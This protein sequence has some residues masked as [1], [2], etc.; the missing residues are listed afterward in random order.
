MGRGDIK[1]NGPLSLVS[2]TWASRITNLIHLFA[3]LVDIESDSGVNPGICEICLFTDDC[4][5]MLTLN[6]LEHLDMSS[7]RLATACM[8]LIYCFMFNSK[9]L[10]SWK[11][12]QLKHS[13]FSLHCFIEMEF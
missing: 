1:W 3:C 2:T 6:R 13:L 7:V 4:Q 9:Q 5:C 8:F 12:R 11:I 10:H